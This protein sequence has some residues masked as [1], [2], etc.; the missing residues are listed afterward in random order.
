VRAHVAESVTPPAAR[1]H[2]SPPTI[3]L[4]SW[5]SLAPTPHSLAARNEVYLYLRISSKVVLLLLS[6]VTK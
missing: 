2:R 3:R 6:R 1:T 4:A 5:S